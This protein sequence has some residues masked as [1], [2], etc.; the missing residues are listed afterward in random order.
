[1][2][3]MG[4]DEDVVA[5]LLEVNEISDL[6]EAIDMYEDHSDSNDDYLIEFGMQY[7]SERPHDIFF[8]E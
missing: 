6:Q 8:R 2:K 4:Y 3:V 5:R 7:S 1:M